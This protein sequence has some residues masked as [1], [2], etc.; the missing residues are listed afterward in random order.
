MH[1]DTILLMTFV[2]ALVAAF[3]GGL[4]ARALR[5]PPIVGYLLGGFAVGPFTPGFIGDSHAMSQLS[6]IGV[7]FMMFGVGMHFSLKD[8]L[9]VK[10]VAIPGAVLQIALGTLAG[11]GLAL[12]LG[13]SIEAGVM[14]GL[15]VSIASTVVLIR[16]L[17]DAGRYQSTG[18]RIATGWLI[19]EDLAT[20]VIL[21]ILPVV[22]GPGEV[23]GPALALQIAEALVLTAVFVALMLVVGTRALPWLLVRIARFCPRELFQLAVV[24]VALGVAMAA[25][26]VFNVSVALGAFLAGVVV[27]GSALSHRIAAEAVPFQ[28][29]F[30]I[31][32]FASVGMMVDPFTLAAHLPELLAIVAL[33]MV[34]KWLINMVLGVVLS[35]GLGTTLTV[36]AGLSQIGEFSFII[37]QLGMSL[38]VLSAEQY[39][40]ILGGAVISIAL[41]SFVFKTVDPLERALG[42]HPLFRRLYDRHVRT[43]ASPEA[44][45]LSDHVVVVGYGHA[46]RCVADVLA[47]LS[48]PCLVVERDLTAAEEAEAAGLCVLQGDAANSTIL[49]HAH[50]V[51]ARLMVIAVGEET[52]AEV[53]AHEARE[54][55]PGLK[56]V[57]RADSDEA[58]SELVAAGAADVVRPELEGGIELMRH[59]LLRLGYRPQQIQ[60]Y[61]NDLRASGYEA[62][63]DGAQLGRV[64]AIERF[65]SAMRG[66]ELD[67]VAVGEGSSLA[68]KTLAESDLRARTGAQVVARRRGDDVA[69]VV[70]P[71]ERVEVGDVLGLVATPE[72]IAAAE[73]ELAPGA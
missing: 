9:A 6:E 25:S 47:R 5:L 26:L 45:T 70:A 23:A 67:W 1:G 63:G 7:M 68:G 39:S 33:I 36:A 28:D 59:A 44:E 53:M 34:G 15:S 57:A 14:L 2:F 52:S 12:A 17:T 64:R 72:G 11:T 60:G 3:V 41:N 40:L 51:Q 38:G 65:M 24:V 42:A 10:G 61:A 29:L 27:S 37:G 32:F 19:V 62:L 56:I 35:A 69:L 54:L 21:V 8:L 71:D 55:A 49:E 46:G 43:V 50:L 16:N 58:V 73:R 22:F 66:L 30:S 31:I 4:V 13:W 20:I 48:V 18:G